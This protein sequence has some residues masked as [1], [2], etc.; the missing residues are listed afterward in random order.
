M[1]ELLAFQWRVLT[2]RA[3]REELEALDPRHLVMGLLWTWAVGI[4][5]W[6][7][8]P[9]AGGMQKLGV[10]SVG[11]VFVLSLVLWL[12]FLALRPRGWSYLRVLSIVTLTAPPAILYAIPIERWMP[13]GAAAQ[14]NLWFLAIVAVWRV[15]LWSYMARRLSTL[16]GWD[17][18]VATALPLM[19]TVVALTYLN[20]ARGILEIMSGMRDPTADDLSAQWVATLGGFSILGGIPVLAAY[21]FRIGRRAKVVEAAM[22]DRAGDAAE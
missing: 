19:L 12:V 22:P 2:F 17:V 10:G 1:W 9:R 18:G 21:V 6:W 7:D 20:L 14:I 8:D 4:G 11:Y 15:A 3:T 16:S 13:V 5:R